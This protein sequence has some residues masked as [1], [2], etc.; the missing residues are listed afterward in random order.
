MNTELKTAIAAYY[1]EIRKFDCNKTAIDAYRLA[2]DTA[3]FNLNY[4]GSY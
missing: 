3:K 1:F 2:I 4:F